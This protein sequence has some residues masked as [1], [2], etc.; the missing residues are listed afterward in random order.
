MLETIRE[1]AAERLADEDDASALGDASRDATSS[2]LAEANAASVGYIVEAGAV[3]RT[4]RERDNILAAIGAAVGESEISPTSSMRSPYC[5]RSCS[6]PVTG[7]KASA[8]RA[9]SSRGVTSSRS[10][11]FTRILVARWRADASRR[12]N[13]T[14][15]RTLKLEL[16]AS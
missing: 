13:S 8:G 14:P 6:R 11:I 10:E 5:G 1:Y 15:L 4:V 9:W 16:V 12:R 7:V 3:E 2:Q